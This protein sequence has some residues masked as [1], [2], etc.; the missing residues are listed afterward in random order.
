M[1]YQRF[2]S[3]FI[4][5]DTID[6]TNNYAANLIK[7]TNVANGT[8]ILTKRQNFGKGQRGN[9]WYSDPEKNLILST[10]I[11]PN[12]AISYAYYL[13]IA[14]ALAVSRTLADFGIE[15]LIKWPN[16]IY[17]QDQKIA[18]ILVE[19]QLQGKLIKSTVAGVGLN[20]NQLSFPD[21]IR[22][23][24][25]SLILGREIQLDKLFRHYFGMLD[26][27]VDVLMQSNFKLLLKLYYK[28]LYRMDVWCNYKD[29]KGPF[30]GKIKGIDER[31]RLVIERREGFNYYNVKELQFLHEA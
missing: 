11:F 1:N 26:F 5:L 4:H 23:T 15:N 27:Y 18:G 20:V 29:D 21:G 25:M 2:E 12:I 16:D 9:T 14:V 30:Q 7:T 6:S 3:N 31:G 13:N 22:G 28:Q 8:T 19:N 24:S 17:A 10:I